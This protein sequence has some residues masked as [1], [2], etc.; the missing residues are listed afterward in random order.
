MPQASLAG[1]R[2]LVADDLETNRALV[3]KMLKRFDAE[4]LLA[5]DGSQAIEL[6]KTESVDIVLMDCQMPVLDGYAATRTIRHELGSDI[7]IIA[8][9]ANALEGDRERCLAAGMTDFL[10]KPVRLNVLREGLSK[11]VTSPSPTRA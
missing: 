11:W 5:E 6:M 3:S 9:T 7:P 4:V 1:V 10:S 8:L 2:I